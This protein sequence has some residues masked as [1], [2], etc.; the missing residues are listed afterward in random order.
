MSGTPKSKSDR[1]VIFPP[2]DVRDEVFFRVWLAAGGDK[3]RSWLTAGGEKRE[4][5]TAES[6]WRQHRRDA[7]KPA[8]IDLV[9]LVSL[10]FR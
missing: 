5:Y 1:N 8:C 9:R 4:I 3:K 2:P 7:L 6:Y 10:S